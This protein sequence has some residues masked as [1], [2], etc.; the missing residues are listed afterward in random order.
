M[1]RIYFSISALLIAV[2]VLPYSIIGA[3]K[4]FSIA[5]KPGIYITQSDFKDFDTGVNGEAQH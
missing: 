5:V 2:S 4:T 1:K 3:D